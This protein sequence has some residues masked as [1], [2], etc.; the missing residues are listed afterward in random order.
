MS[1]RVNVAV[2][3]TAAVGKSAFTVQ[4]TQGTFSGD[5][6]PTIE[7]RHCIRKHVDGDPI[8]LEILDT[9]GAES[10]SSMRDM[11]MKEQDA[12]VILYSVIDRSSFD[13]LKEYMRKMQHIRDCEPSAVPCV[14]VGNKVDLVEGETPECERAVSVDEGRALASSWGCKFWEGSAKLGVNVEPAFVE[15]IRRARLVQRDPHQARRKASGGCEVMQRV[16]PHCTIGRTGVGGTLQSHNAR[17]SRARW[18]SLR[19]RSTS[20]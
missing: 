13:A 12:F 10:F 5:Y 6:E 3:G 4:M 17:T 20:S 18:S 2:L 16:L 15:C 9:A 8:Q 14:L 7:E 11:Y 19:R 1:A